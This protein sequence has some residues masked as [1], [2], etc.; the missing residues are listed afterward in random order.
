MSSLLGYSPSPAPVQKT[1]AKAAALGHMALS[2]FISSVYPSATSATLVAPVQP[3]EILDHL[4][5]ASFD[6][7]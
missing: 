4:A 1:S 7:P 5:P 6:L 3:I 2:R